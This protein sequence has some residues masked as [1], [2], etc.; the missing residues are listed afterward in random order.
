MDVH[1]TVINSISLPGK[2]V[3]GKNG[4]EYSGDYLVV[5]A[6]YRLI[7]PTSQVLRSLLSRCIHCWMPNVCGR[8]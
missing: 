8:G 5:A 6:G 2:T 7:S 4:D 3:T 1:M